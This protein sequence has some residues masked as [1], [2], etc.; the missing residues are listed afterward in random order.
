MPYQ[1]NKEIDISNYPNATKLYVRY[2]DASGGISDIYSADIPPVGVSGQISTQLPSATAEAQ[3]SSGQVSQAPSTTTQPSFTP[4]VSQEKPQEQI[5]IELVDLNIPQEVNLGERV[6]ITA[7]VK[8][9]SKLS[10]KNCS[11]SLEIED[12]FKEQKGF[13]LKAETLERIKFLWQPKKEGIFKVKAEVLIPE[14][15]VDK[16][17]RNNA[18]EE[19]IKVKPKVEVDLSIL[20]ISLPPEVHIGR[21]VEIEITVLNDSEIEAKD[22]ELNISIGDGSR[23]KKTL[24]LKPKAREKSIFRWTPRSE[25]N[26]RIEVKIDPP[27]GLE[28]KNIR[29][30]T[31]TKTVNVEI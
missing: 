17:T 11:L 18:I 6:E 29:N 15:L 13:S 28:D 20:D 7:R 25:G 31:S 16:D 4:S 2:A 30:N 21:E 23:D 27:K 1:T 8:N 10:I 3:V 26:F 5:E 9:Y 12:G 19:R 14:G 24:S 22:C